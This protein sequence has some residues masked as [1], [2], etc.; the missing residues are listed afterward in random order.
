MHF[1]E[2]NAQYRELKLVASG[3]NTENQVAD[4]EN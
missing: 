4:T 1:G 2:F 3:S